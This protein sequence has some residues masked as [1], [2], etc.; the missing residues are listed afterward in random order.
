MATYYDVDLRHATLREFAF[1]TPWYSMPLVTLL[2]FAGFRFPCS[3]DDP[4]VE[5]LAPFEVDEV[6]LPDEVHTKKRGQRECR[7]LTSVKYYSNHLTSPN[8]L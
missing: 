6:A 4:P 2:K 8:M 7:C 1:G 3:T 5:A